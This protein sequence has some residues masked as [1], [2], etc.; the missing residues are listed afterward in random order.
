MCLLKDILN[1]NLSIEARQYLLASR[2]VALNKPTGDPRPIAV[3][4]L[5]YRL[6][7]VI[8]VNRVSD[9]AAK[10]LAPHQYGV[11]VP[12]GAER[13]L[14]SVQHALTDGGG[15]KALLKIDIGN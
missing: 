5:L 13:I 8:A 6:A 12:S 14:H 15:H 4:E 1:D 9:A 7:A 2:L 3:G 10:L 11:G